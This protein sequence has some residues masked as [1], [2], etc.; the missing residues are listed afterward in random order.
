MERTLQSIYLDQV[1]F[2]NRD[3]NSIIKNVKNRVYLDLVHRTDV[4]PGLGWMISRSIWF[5]LREKWPEAFWDDWIR[6]SDQ[7]KNRAC[8]RPE[9]SRTQ[10]SEYGKKGVSQ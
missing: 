4:F 3:S 7:R 1:L 9:I 6:H 5:E 10:I 2:Y 8:L